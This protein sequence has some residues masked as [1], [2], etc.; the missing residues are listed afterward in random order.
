MARQEN[1][2]I[3]KRQLDAFQKGDLDT[4]MSQF[5]PDAVWH[6]P[7]KSLLAGD[8]KGIDAIRGFLTRAVAE[9]Q[10]TFRLELLDAAY[11]DNNIFQWNRITASRGGRSLNEREL[12]VFTVRNGK[13]VEVHHRP[14]QQLLDEF[15]S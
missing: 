10:G 3:H 6:L 13:I 2:A 12:L 8:H 5:S 11:S 14:E 7:G 1:E 9:T 15:Y 4:V